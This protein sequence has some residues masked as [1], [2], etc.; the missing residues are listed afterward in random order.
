MYKTYSKE[1]YERTLSIY[2]QWC[3]GVKKKHLAK[4]YGLSNLQI[5]YACKR[6]PS[7]ILVDSHSLIYPKELK[8]IRNIFACMKQ[9]CNNP[10]S[11]DYKYYGG[12]GIKCEWNNFD[13]F[14]KDMKKG[15]KENL[16]I[17]R[18]DVNKNYCKENC[19][20]V[21][22]N[23]QQQNRRSFLEWDLK[24]NYWFKN[25]KTKLNCG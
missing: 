7:L 4:K 18:I 14:Y 12:R 5:K 23:L 6:A 21:V 1:R 2:K 8:R 15:Y 10:K 13:D 25:K 22:K 24:S 3:L 16:T 17:D 20:W 11:K 19:R 9:R